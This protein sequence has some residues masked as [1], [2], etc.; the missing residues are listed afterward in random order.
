MMKI[1]LK[2]TKHSEVALFRNIFNKTTI[3]PDF[4][5]L[6]TSVKWMGDDTDPQLPMYPDCVSWARLIVA[7][8]SQKF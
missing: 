5:L 6:N 2:L 1:G 8:Y 3:L 4:T 7:V